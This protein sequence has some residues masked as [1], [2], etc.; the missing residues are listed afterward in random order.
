MNVRNSSRTNDRIPS[1]PF[2][3]MGLVPTR[4]NRTRLI[5][6]SVVPEWFC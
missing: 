1:Q 3:K 6:H 4:A 5:M 2:A